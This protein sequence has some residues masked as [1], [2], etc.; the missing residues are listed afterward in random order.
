M[1]KILFIE[2]EITRNIPVLELLFGSV[3][4][5]DERGKLAQLRR[6]P[7]GASIEKIKDAL[8]DNQ[9]L[10][11]ESTFA[12]AID[13]IKAAGD[14]RDYDLFLIDRNLAT[15]NGM[16]KLEDIE[17]VMPGYDQN[18]LERYKG[19]EGDFLL[20]LLHLQGVPCRE[21]VYFYSAYQADDIRSALYL[22]HM[23]G[24][25]TFSRKNFVDKS[26][27][28]AKERFRRNV[29]EHLDR[30]MVVAR[31]PDVFSGLHKVGLDD[32]R[33][34][35]IDILRDDS[36][37]NA[38]ARVLLEHFL[39]AVQFTEKKNYTWRKPESNLD[40]DALWHDDEHGPQ[41]VPRFVYNHC[42][43]IKRFCNNYVSHSSEKEVAKGLPGPTVYSWLA[44]KFMLADMFT[45]L[46]NEL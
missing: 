7:L 18:A 2:D 20:L 13:R 4:S 8:Q 28:G 19:R 14:G 29:V 35:L 43:T 42:M 3:I 40:F 38:D 34:R 27:P 17:A 26:D 10:E 45:W 15:G 32:D 41:R 11:I 1:S 39:D 12:G 37:P 46:D 24:Y 5:K 31:Y 30:A 16:Y 6:S 36:V 44:V 25:E 33:D 22:Q 9:V 23:I 21:K